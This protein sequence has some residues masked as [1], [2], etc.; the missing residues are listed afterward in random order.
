MGFL[1]T[2]EKEIPNGS[3]DLLVERPDCSIACEISVSTTIDHEV[4]NVQKCI[5]AGFATVA[6]ICQEDVRARRIKEAAITS[7]G[8]DAAKC[9][10]CFHPEEFIAHLKS[11]GAMVQ[12]KPVSDETNIRR[13]YKVRRTI[14]K[15]AAEERKA[16]EDAAIAQIAALM[17]RRPAT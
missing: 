10:I 13:G 12:P 1:A 11:L 14:G 5:Q 2:I 4:G 9:V 15:L 6:I 16:R 7:L 17:K 3:I 8:Q